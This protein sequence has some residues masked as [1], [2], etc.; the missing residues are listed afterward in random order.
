MDFIWTVYTCTR[1][2][3]CVV[4]NSLCLLS[5]LL[6]RP[7]SSLSSSPPLLFHSHD[8][9]FDS[10]RWP[11][12]WCLQKTQF[13]PPPLCTPLAGSIEAPPSVLYLRLA[14]CVLKLHSLLWGRAEWIEGLTVR[15]V[16]KPIPAFGLWLLSLLSSCPLLCPKTLLWPIPSHLPPAVPR[17][18]Q[19]GLC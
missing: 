13:S 19:T 9:S 8:L 6:F 10:S 18:S 11:S 14:S 2:C 1:Y 4:L 12:R 15:T 7:P 17:V 5:F 16:R 3:T